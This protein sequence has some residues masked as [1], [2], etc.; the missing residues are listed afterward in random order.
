MNISDRGYVI[1]QNQKEYYMKKTLS[2]AVLAASIAA[3]TAISSC[4]DNSAYDK[5]TISFAELT[6]SRTYRLDQSA[7]DFD[8]DHDL[9]FYDSVSLLV[10]TLIGDNDIRA[11]QDTI[12]KLA[13][14]TT[15]VDHRAIIDKYFETTASDTGYKAIEISADSVSD[16]SADGFEIVCGNVVNLDAMFTVYCI[17][18]QSYGLHAAHGMTVK[19]YVNYLNDSGKVLTMSDLFSPQGLKELPELIAK[20]ANELST[21]IGPT[22][23]TALPSTFYISA[24]GEIMFVYQPYEIASFAQGIISIPFYPYELVDYMT[25]E[26]IDLFN[27][28]DLND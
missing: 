9:V 25:A 12:F 28:V 5:K 14:D 15:G 2:I 17:T 24:A 11:F 23:V 3:M 4:K 13:F 22:D 16:R 19:Q 7:K 10:P 21:I 20:R 26:G 27:L 18:N 8:T 6:E 1:N